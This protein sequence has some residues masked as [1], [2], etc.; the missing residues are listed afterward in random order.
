M[1]LRKSGVVSRI[2]DIEKRISANVPLD[3]GKILDEQAEDVFIPLPGSLGA[4]TELIFVAFDCTAQGGMQHVYV[5]E[6]TLP[7]DGS[8]NWLYREE[9]PLHALGVTPT[10]LTLIDEK[11]VQHFADAPLPVNSL[12]LLDP[13]EESQGSEAFE[14]DQTA[15]SS[16]DGR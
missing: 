8:V 1:K 15:I 14:P 12:Q 6:A 7:D 13:S 5:G 2:F 16:L 11:P 10:V 9:L 4:A 3:F